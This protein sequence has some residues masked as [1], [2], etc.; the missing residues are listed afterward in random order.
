[1]R[2]KLEQQAYVEFVLTIP[3][4]TK[5]GYY[6]VYYYLLNSDS[7]IDIYFSGQERETP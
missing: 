7:I 5:R 4:S 3:H 1:M 6:F 2:K